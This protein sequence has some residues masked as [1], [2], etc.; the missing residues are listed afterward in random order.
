MQGGARAHTLACP[1]HDTFHPGG[2]A[3]LS[4]RCTAA[5]FARAPARCGLHER[6]LKLLPSAVTHLSVAV[7]DRMSWCPTARQLTGGCFR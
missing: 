5:L 7:Q 3:V 1:Q 4:L 6:Q 2:S